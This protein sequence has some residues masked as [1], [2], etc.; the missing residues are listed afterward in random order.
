MG[1]L[2]PP[3]TKWS[4]GVVVYIDDPAVWQAVW[5][6]ADFIERVPAV[7]FFNNLCCLAN[8]FSV[9]FHGFPLW[10]SDCCGV[11]LGIIGFFAVSRNV[12]VRNY[13]GLW[14]EMFAQRLCSLYLNVAVVFGQKFKSLFLFQPIQIIIC[15]PNL[16]EIG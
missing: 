4:C 14:L 15:V 2:Y 3:I 6:Q 13:F 16:I 5:I 7:C 8:L 1:H 9:A 10:C 11:K 12:F